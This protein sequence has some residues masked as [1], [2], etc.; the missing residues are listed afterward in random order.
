[1]ACE[2]AVV[3][4]A[5]GGIPEVVLDGETG[6]LVPIEQVDDGSGTPVDPDAFV[7]D[8]AAALNEAVSD[9]DRARAFGRAGR[10]R[11]VEHFSW[12]SIGDQTLEV[13]RAVL[14]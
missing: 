14:G 1:M 9:P 3:A 8:L 2:L 10:A 5:T 12:G 7:A 4:T 6:W 13:Y 11:A